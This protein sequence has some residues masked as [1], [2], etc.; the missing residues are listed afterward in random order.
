[1]SVKLMSKTPLLALLYIVAT[2]LPRPLNAQELDT[3][4][5]EFFEAKVRPLLIAHCYECHSAEAATA[6]N[7][8]GG[9]RL[10][11]R[12]GVHQGGDSGAIIVAGKPD[13]S[14]L[15]KSVRYAD[16]GLQMP[17][18]EPLSAD[19]VAVLEKWVTMGAPDPREGSAP[20]AAAKRGIFRVRMSSASCTIRATI[21]AARGMS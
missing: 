14:A 21:S 6:E 19:Q 13:E 7:L 11:N 3:S 10:D 1:M 17:P 12:A 16:K 4:S 8:Q 20:V 2:S 18:K 9:L 5:I 15:I